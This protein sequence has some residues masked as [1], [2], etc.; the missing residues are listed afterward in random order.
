MSHEIRTP[1][2][3]IL[4]FSKLLKDD[5]FSHQEKESFIQTINSHGEALL[6]LIDDIIDISMIESDQLTLSPSY[7][8]VNPIMI[9]LE[10]Y[11][12]LNNKNQLIIEFVNRNEKEL[13]LYL[14]PVRFRQI[15]INLLSNALKYTHR[16][17]IRFGYEKSENDLRFFV[18]DSGIGIDPQYQENIFEHFYKIELQS[19]KIY[20]G[21]G[22][23]LAICKQLVKLLDGK[24]WF[25]STPGN[26][27]VF[28]FSIPYINYSVNETVKKKSSTSD[29]SHLLDKIFFVIAED[30]RA[31]YEV[32]VKMLHISEDRHFWGVNGREVVDYVQKLENQDNIVVLMDIKM[33]EMDGYKAMKM[34]KKFNPKIP[35]IAITAF[36]LKH[37]EKEFLAKGFDAY[38]PKPISADK[39]KK[40]IADFL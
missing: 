8:D 26:G 30:E 25:E 14:D 38:I 40:V 37:E 22:I 10:D 39:V 16:G 34:I 18:A 35:I 1:M 36:A 13:I 17:F 11:C 12:R 32:L 29:P 15:M 7:F 24:I 33:P 20:R 23:G 2:N 6:V 28:Y 27:T 31:N 21:T 19:N 9:E 4:G 5:E 3:A